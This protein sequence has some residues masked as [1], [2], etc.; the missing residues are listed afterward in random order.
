MSANENPFEPPVSPIGADKKM[1]RLKKFA[2]AVLASMIGSGMVLALIVAVAIIPEFLDSNEMPK[3]VTREVSKPTGL[4]IS[5]QARVADT[6]LFTVQG[7]IE[8]QGSSEWAQ[9]SIEATV[10]VAGAKVNRC[11]DMIYGKISP[12]TRHAF[13]I[14]CAETPGTGLPANTDYKVSITSARKRTE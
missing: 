11:R 14:E 12:R 9:V 10:S 4:R 7:V 8:N 13:Q 2:L 6:E 1:S 3:N 5:E